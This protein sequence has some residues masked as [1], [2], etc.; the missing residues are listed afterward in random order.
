MPESFV[1]FLLTILVAHTHVLL[2]ALI[3]LDRNGNIESFLGVEVWAKLQAFGS[4]V[5]H[6]QQ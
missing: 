6:E 1:K 5:F 4:G 2:K 3:M